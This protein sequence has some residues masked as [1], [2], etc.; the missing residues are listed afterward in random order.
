MSWGF[1]GDANRRS[2]RAVAEGLAA[3]VEGRKAHS[4]YCSSESDIE[5]V[6]E[7]LKA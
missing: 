5:I 7:L 1:R 3:E 6:V 4:S 2:S